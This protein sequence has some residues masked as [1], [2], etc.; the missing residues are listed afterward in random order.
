MALEVTLPALLASMGINAYNKSVI[1]TNELTPQSAINHAEALDAA[2][3]ARV[4]EIAPD[5]DPLRIMVRANQPGNEYDGVKMASH[6]RGTTKD[7]KE[8]SLININP[9]A[10][11]SIYAHELGHGVSQKTKIGS[12]VNRARHGLGNNPALAKALSYGLSLG[13]PAVGSA[14]Q[15]GDDDLLGSIGLAAAMASPRLVDE[16]LASKNALAIMDTAGMRATAGQRGRLAGGMLSYLGA[17][18]LLGASAN[19]V[20]NQFDDPAQTDGTLMP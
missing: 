18:L 9:N 13:V 16:A 19:L 10:D 1:G 12:L 5:A 11:A 8:F 7:G 17:P 2:A 3:K 6:Q 15:E 14:L 4:S 20:G